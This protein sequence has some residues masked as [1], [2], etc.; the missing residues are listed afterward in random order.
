MVVLNRYLVEV[1]VLI[2]HHLLLRHLNL[3]SREIHVV[4]LVVRKVVVSGLRV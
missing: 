3:L 1:V 4:S 2:M